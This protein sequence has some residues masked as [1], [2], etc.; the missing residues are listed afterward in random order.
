MV[1]IIKFESTKALQ[2]GLSSQPVMVDR[3]RSRSPARGGEV[4]DEHE[5]AKEE[6]ILNL[7]QML[8]FYNQLEKICPQFNPV[9]PYLANSKKHSTHNTRQSQASAVK[10]KEDDPNKPFRSVSALSEVPSEFDERPDI[11]RPASKA[12]KYE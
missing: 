10:P 5:P 2:S 9:E 6:L 8:Q 11:F 12:F 4:V 1:W 3:S 7:Q